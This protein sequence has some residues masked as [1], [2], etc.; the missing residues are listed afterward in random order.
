MISMTDLT[1]TEQKII[2]DVLFHLDGWRTN[3]HPHETR[4][5]E[6]FLDTSDP[7][8]D[9]SIRKEVSSRE[10]LSAYDLAKVHAL[11]YIRRKEF[12]NNPSIYQAIC[13]WAAGILSE[14]SHFKEGKIDESTLLIEEA[15]KLL[16]PHV[17][18]G[19]DFFI[20]S[21]DEFFWEEYMRSER[22]PH[23]R[24]DRQKDE[25]DGDEPKELLTHG[26][27]HEKHRF[28][29]FHYKPK[30][31]PVCPKPHHH[32]KGKPGWIKRRV[33]NKYIICI[34]PVIST[35]GLSV[36]LKAVVK[37]GGKPCDYGKLL[38]YIYD[39]KRMFI[40]S[41]EVVEG[42]AEYDWNIPDNVGRGKK[43]I[44]A[45]FVGSDDYIL[46]EEWEDI[47]LK[48]PTTIVLD[49]DETLVS[50]SE[51]EQ[52]HNLP[53]VAH[54][55]EKF[56]DKPVNIGN[57]QFLVKTE[58][59]SSFIDMGEPVPVVNGLAE[60]QYTLPELYQTTIFFKAIYLTND[61][62]F[63][64]ETKDSGS[65]YV[66]GK[67]NLTIEPLLANRGEDISIDIV[68]T[69]IDGSEVNEG[70]MNIYLDDGLIV[71]EMSALTHIVYT[72]TL[73]DEIMWGEHILRV[74]YL[75]ND[76]FDCASS[77]TFLYIRTPVVLNSEYVYASQ[78]IEDNGSIIQGVASIPLEVVDIEGNN[79]NQG[80]LTFTCGSTEKIYQLDQ[81]DEEDTEISYNIPLGISGG[82]EIPY[83]LSYYGTDTYQNS[84][85]Q[86]KIIIRYQ[87]NVDVDPIN[88][89]LG[90]TITLNAGVTDEN[91]EGVNEGTVDFDLNQEP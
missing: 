71:K 52:I 53:L 76:N 59:D 83:T 65:T 74:E 25:W 15:R 79:V 10:V 8:F 17:K 21:G 56:T 26:H 6:S 36:L 84:T 42:K 34:N 77:S 43:K 39:T 18:R 68:V 60:Y 55:T 2:D 13:Y 72:Y 58:D 48:I 70:E 32:N 63:G 89:E 87:T 49:N 54:V 66:K 81:L 31:K 82:A 73:S 51:G 57:V 46:C 23:P 90:D 88:A 19:E 20:V 4:K 11:N 69:N 16:A 28:N 80:T 29:R 22:R 50:G 44:Y 24:R 86:S 3:D 40:G 67:V 14:K 85:V 5:I 30:Q 47:F 45:T 9:N 35:D 91:N 38:F 12:P 7:H 61:I 41:S 75:E 27:F 37:K 78:T 33:K 62:Y 64:C 1:S